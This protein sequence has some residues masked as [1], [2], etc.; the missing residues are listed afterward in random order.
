M[1]KIMIAALVV[2]SC[3][4][5]AGGGHAD[6]SAPVSGYYDVQ[7]SSKRL[8]HATKTVTK[9]WSTTTKTVKGERV[10]T[11]ALDLYNAEYPAITNQAGY[12]EISYAETLKKKTDPAERENISR[13]T[14]KYTRYDFRE[15]KTQRKDEEGKVVRDASNKPVYDYS[16][17]YVTKI[18]TDN[19][20]GVYDAKT[21]KVY[22]WNTLAADKVEV[23]K[24]ETDVLNDEIAWKETKKGSGVYKSVKGFKA[25]EVPL[26][27]HKQFIKTDDNKAAGGFTGGEAIATDGTQLDFTGMTAFGTGTFDA[28]KAIVK[29]VS[30]NIAGKYPD[31]LKYGCY[32]TWKINLDTNSDKYD[33]LKAAL[34]K[35]GCVELINEVV[36]K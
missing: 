4:A 7:I 12:V 6:L 2:A 36:A 35:K 25:Y 33:S 3:T 18:V 9:I 17:N 13:I 1:K 24:G 20:K 28:K 19:V 30:G 29:T 10:T 34:V 5:F 15:V 27:M 31:D 16:T 22:T 14:L 21:G 11:Y 32:G 8:A 26:A 23:D